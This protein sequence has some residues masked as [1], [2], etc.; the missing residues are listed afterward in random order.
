MV[1][2]LP[3]SEHSYQFFNHIKEAFEK[4]VWCCTALPLYREAPDICIH[5][6]VCVCTCLSVCLSVHVH[7]H[8]CDWICEN[9]HSS[10]IQ[11]FNFEKIHKIWC[12]YQTGMKLARIV[13]QLSLYVPCKFRICMLFQSHFMNL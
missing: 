1:S 2:S 9:M 4:V 3:T 7:M 11:F 6:C 12:V 5:V 10:H 8:I 13:V